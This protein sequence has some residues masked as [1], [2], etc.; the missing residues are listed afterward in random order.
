V[1]YRSLVD[2]LRAGDRLPAQTIDATLTASGRT[3]RDLLADVLLRPGPRPGDACPCGCGG[4]LVVYFSKS[5]GDWQSQRLRCAKCHRK[6]I[7]NKIVVPADSIRRRNRA[8]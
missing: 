3:H 5:L 8:S 4:R 6:P 2:R 1:D 7:P